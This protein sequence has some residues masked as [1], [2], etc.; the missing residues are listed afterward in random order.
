MTA[1]ELFEKFVKY[2]ESIGKFPTIQE[3]SD[4]SKLPIDIVSKVYKRWYNQGKLDK[5]GNSYCFHKEDKHQLFQEERKPVDEPELEIIMPR[6]EKAADT[7]E[8]EPPK[9]DYLAV[10]LRVI[11]GIIGFLLVFCSIHFTYNFNG[12]SMKMFWAFSLSVSIVAFMAIAFTLMDYIP[13]K[14]LKAF[15]FVLWILGFV[16]SV[17]TAVSGQYNDFRKYL[18]VDKTE[19][20]ESKKNIINE[21]LDIQIKKQNELLHWREQETEYSLNPDLKTENPGTWKKIQEGLIKLEE[22]ESKIEE[23]QNQI[24]DIVE[25]DTVSDETVYAWLCKI[26]KISSDKLHFIIILFP[27]VFID[28]CSGVCLLFAFKKKEE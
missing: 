12:M 8:E 2:S 18:S 27:S 5:N 16:Y 24:I 10:V 9:K 1:D 14:S 22:T 20:I 28:L 4:Y 17:F 6:K 26:L 15:V 7:P 21:Q 11:V 13:K 19:V 25:V 23:L 3:F